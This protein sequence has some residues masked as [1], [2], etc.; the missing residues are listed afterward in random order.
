MPALRERRRPSTVGTTLDLLVSPELYPLKIDRRRGTMSFVRMS[1]DSYRDSVFLDGRTRHVG[2]DVL[3]ARLDDLLLASANA[4]A[5]AGRVHYILHMAFC[6][7]T[8]LARY[9]ELL[10]SCFVL[11]EPRLLT[12]VALESH[13][14][15]ERGE[16][17]FGL[18]VR[19]LTRSY[20]A[21]QL[22][23]IKVN[24]W[25]NSLGPRLLRANDSATA[26]FLTTP[27]RHF[28]LSVLKSQT[29]RAW[30]HHRIQAAAR[31][32]AAS[33]LAAVPLDDLTDAQAAAYLWLVNRSLCASLASHA[34]LGSRVL[35]LDGRQVA[36]GPEAALRAVAALSGLPLGDEKLAWMLAQPTR[37]SYSKDLSRRYDAEARQAEERE[38]LERLG[39]EAQLGV[40]WAAAQVGESEDALAA[41]PAANANSAASR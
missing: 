2:A 18:C 14:V 12:Q 4:P 22:V 39:P 23:V 20:D 9:L 37:Q 16:E 28:V 15:A 10:P 29:R 40:A 33:A 32:A 38:L 21:E 24:D 41:W 27:L 8:L 36:E 26:T 13:R 6:C 25:C 1:P 19:L 30:V 5:R 31:D 3:E 11:K 7:S 35:V 17:S 34:Q